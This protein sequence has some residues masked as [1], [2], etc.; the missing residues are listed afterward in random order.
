MRGAIGY[1]LGEDAIGLARFREKYVAKMNDGPDRRAFDVVTAPIGT[2][3]DEFREVVRSIATVD[4]LEAFLRDLRGRYPETGAMPTGQTSAS[5]PRVKK[6]SQI[7][8]KGTSARP[9]SASGLTVS[10]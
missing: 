1:T 7:A 10:G 8:P 5:P 4:T 3:G 2:G 9:A 6:T